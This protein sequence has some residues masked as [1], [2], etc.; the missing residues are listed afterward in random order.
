MRTLDNLGNLLVLVPHIRLLNVT[1]DEI[2]MMEA[3][4]DHVSPLIDLRTFVLRCYNHFWT[5]DELRSLMN[6]LPSIEQ[7]SLQLSS[8]DERF[9]NREQIFFEQLSSHIRRFDFAMRYFYE[10]IDEIDCSSFVRARFP[11]VCLIDDELQQAVLH[12]LPYRFP[13][14]NISTTMAKQMSTYEQYRH[15]DMFYDYHGMTLA[16]TFPIIARCQRIKEIA[17]QSYE[18]TPD[19]PSAGTTQCSTTSSVHCRSRSSSFT[20]DNIAD[21]HLFE[22]CLAFAFVT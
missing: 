2:S 7:L 16:E 14:L 13:L 21:T 10:T 12:T 17:I 15:V 22:T 6:C 4:Y 5:Y 20:S 8:Q 11:L 3:R 18:P 9:V 19:V 1:I